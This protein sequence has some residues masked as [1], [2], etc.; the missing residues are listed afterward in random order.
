M[1]VK[2]IW[3]VTRKQIE[4]LFKLAN[5]EDF[6]ITRIEK[7]TNCG[8]K[9]LVVFAESEWG[10]DKEDTVMVEDEIV[11]IYQQGYEDQCDF[12]SGFK[13]QPDKYIQWELWCGLI[14]P[15]DFDRMS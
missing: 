10:V 2:N 7:D 13:V 14:E 12:S 1:A 6:K 8:D 11:R 3:G 15:I 5:F 9:C 4:V